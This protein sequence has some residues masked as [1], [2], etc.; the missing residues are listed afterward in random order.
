MPGCWC[1]EMGWGA[2]DGRRQDVELM[3]KLVASEI[4]QLRIKQ[5]QREKKYLM[6]NTSQQSKLSLLSGFCDNHSSSV[7]ARCVLTI[8]VGPGPVSSHS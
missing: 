1:T 2:G 4:R 3:G 5:M 8:L 7:A 6:V